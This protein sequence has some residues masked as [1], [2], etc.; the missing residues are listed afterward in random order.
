MPV[1]LAIP[2]SDELEQVCSKYLERVQGEEPRADSRRLLSVM[3]MAI[4]ESLRIVVLDI[5]EHAG[6]GRS[7]YAVASVTEKAILKI[8]HA[9][10]RRVI[11]QM[12]LEHHVLTAEYMQGFLRH[13]DHPLKGHHPC[14]V[15]PMEHTKAVGILQMVERSKVDAAS[16][17]R[18]EVCDHLVELLNAWL[19]A[20]L[21]KPLQ[22]LNIDSIASTVAE[23]SVRTARVTLHKA[24][25]MAY[26]FVDTP[27]KVKI[28]EYLGQFFI[29]DEAA[30]SYP[31][32]IVASVA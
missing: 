32:R 25:Y 13:V 27:Q 5:L 11:K 1:M 30:V 15:I 23:K 3:S 14:L 8:T 17:S 19:D 26:R 16:M 10:L 31:G 28:G 9:I 24:S 22:M 18:E 7:V 20:V 21:E 6:L 4:E 12:T 2:V 29:D